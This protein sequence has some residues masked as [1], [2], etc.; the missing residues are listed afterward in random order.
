MTMLSTKTRSLQKVTTMTK[1]E[2]AHIDTTPDAHLLTVVDRDTDNVVNNV[3]EVDCAA[4]WA[5]I[6]DLDAEGK[7]QY[8]EKNQVLT[9]VV[10]GN[11]ALHRNY[12]DE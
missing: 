5:R 2:Y 7:W 3:V 1:L 11:Y 12:K 6:V 10:G 8:D 9:V 4:G